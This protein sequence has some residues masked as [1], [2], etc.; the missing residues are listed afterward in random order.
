MTGTNY[1]PQYTFQYD[2]NGRLSGM[3]DVAAGNMTVATASYGVAGEMTGLS[4]NWYNQ[5]S[6]SET[7][8]YNA[9]LQLT[10]MTGTGMPYGSPS[11]TVLDMQYDY[12]LGAN[13]GRIA[14]ATDWVAGE[15]VA[16]G[17]DPLNRL[18]TAGATNG[19]WAQT[20]SYDGFGNLTG[21]TQGGVP[22]LNVGF[23]PATNRQNGLT[24]D[25]N[26][27]VGT[28]AYDVE[29]RVITDASGSYSYDPSGKRVKK[30]NG[31]AFEFYFYGIGGQKLVTLPCVSTENG[32][33]CPVGNQYNVY[34]GGRLVKSKGVAVATDRLGSVR[35]NSNGEKMSFYPYGEERTSTADGREKF[36]TYTRDNAT[37]DYADQR[38]YA[39]GAGRFN[40]ADPYQASN[41]GAGDATD[42]ASWNRYAF[43]AGDPI[44]LKDPHGLFY[45]PAGPDPDPDPLPPPGPSPGP[46]PPRR[47]LPEPEPDPNP[48]PPPPPAYDPCNS[49]AAVKFVKAYLQDAQALAAKLKVP[50][51][52][53]L[54][55][56][57]MESTYGTSDIAQR[58]NNFFGIHWG[59]V[60]AA[61]GATQSITN[62]IVA[63]W[64]WG[65]DGFMGSGNTMVALAI[66][67]G[68]TGATNAL[69][70]FTAIHKQF[71]V[72]N[73]NYASNMVSAVNSVTARLKCP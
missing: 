18:T 72:P 29:N 68:A 13:N 1:G 9:M 38:Y 43:V 53:V 57:A 51:E 58:E 55:L 62:P 45:G 12:T 6:Y 59:S 42:P 14:Q 36:A 24:Y 8:Q 47:D 33:G 48:E 25:A 49:T 17:Y 41:G 35:A 71:G 64:D 23:D 5:W 22:V 27:N 31:V 30:G 67:D 52:W 19:S 32:L 10:R 34:F 39:V 60:A 26:G 66:S 3:Q 21:K 50:G 28:G 2:A 16:Y 40:S 69:D 65:T 46:N 11:A 44:N 20:Y 15:T 63:N 61:N 4:Y 7:R 70:F 37:T 56:G 73:A 54:A